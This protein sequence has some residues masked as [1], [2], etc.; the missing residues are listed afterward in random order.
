VFSPCQRAGAATETRATAGSALNN[1]VVLHRQ[2]QTARRDA[3]PRPRW[4]GSACCVLLCL[5]GAATACSRSRGR[6]RDKTGAP[7]R[8][9]DP[10]GGR[11]TKADSRHAEV[12]IPAAVTLPALPEFQEKAAASGGV[13]KVHLEA[14]PPHLNPL[15]DG[16]QVIAR[17]VNGLVY[18]SLIE[19]R[20]RDYSP[21]LAESWEVSPDGLRIILRLRAGL[22]WQDDKPVTSVDVQATLE[23]ILRRT[24]HAQVLR[25]SLVDIESVEVMP[26]RAIRLRLHRPAPFVLRALCD[27]PILPEALTRGDR[28]EIAQLSRQPVGSGPFRFGGWE[29]GKRIRLVRNPQWWR[30]PAH[31]DEIVFEIDGD[32]SR[33]LARVRRGDIDILPRVAE[34]HYPDQVIPAALGDRVGL[35]RLSPERYSFLVV[36]QRTEAMRDVRFR[37]AISLL[38][39]RQKL[40]EDLHRGLAEPIGGP[41]FGAVPAPEF[42]LPRAIRLLEEGGYVDTNGDG[43]RDRAGVPLR[44]T[45]AHAAGV[46]SLA[47]EARRFAADLRRAGLLLE[48]VP[49]DPAALVERLRAGQF[50]LAPVAWEGRPDEDPRPLFGAHGEFNYGGFRSDSVQALLEELRMAATPAARVPIFDRLA[51]ALADELPVIFL[52]RHR[53]AALVSRRVHGLS[54]DAGNIDLRAAWVDP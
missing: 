2:G 48:I 13:L 11:A 17:V 32:S 51:T 39:N 4:V 25:A 29:R 37:R 12:E 26:E 18:E 46:R 8:A 43:V 31:L 44:L 6:D 30:G 27:V 23:G 16:H 38:W 45:F 40:A 33:A 35:V 21:G 5:L 1:T 24:S 28:A 14:E 19:C 53:G 3:P 50:D 52:Y 15:Q 20:G 10:G 49:V 54:E 36:G 47:T 7:A 42:D 34:V 41:P 22:R 9:D